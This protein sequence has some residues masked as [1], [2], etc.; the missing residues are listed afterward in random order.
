[1]ASAVPHIVTAT[2]VAQGH[3]QSTHTTLQLLRTIAVRFALTRWHF[4]QH[5][6]DKV[7][8]ESDHKTWE[9]LSLASPMQD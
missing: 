4:T 6:K 7:S 8:H 2:R 1:M 3:V 5:A 9:L